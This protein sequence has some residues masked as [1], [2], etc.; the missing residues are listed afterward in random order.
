VELAEAGVPKTD[1]LKDAFL[2]E[3]L[4]GV[5]WTPPGAVFCLLY[6]MSPTAAGGG[7]EVVGGGYVRQAA[8]F[9]A[10]VD[11]VSSNT[12]AVIFPLATADWGD[13][14]AYGIID[15]ATGGNL[16]YWADL[17]TTYPIFTSDQWK[18][19]VGQLVV[20]ED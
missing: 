15:A 8:T 5:A 4:R 14:V 13:V 16:L 3:A 6:T 18:F 20:R 17:T 1:Y 11:G 12:V 9:G 2:D 10:P 19:P 7:T